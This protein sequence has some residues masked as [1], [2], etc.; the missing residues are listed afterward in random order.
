MGSHRRSHFGSSRRFIRF[1][2]SSHYLFCVL[3]C[4]CRCMQPLAP[5]PSQIHEPVVL[6]DELSK[7]RLYC[8]H[9]QHTLQSLIEGCPLGSNAGLQLIEDYVMQVKQQ[10]QPIF[11]D[12]EVPFQAFAFV[13]GRHR[14]FPSCPSSDAFVIAAVS[15][16]F[17]F[18]IQAHF[19]ELCTQRTVALSKFPKLAC[20][21]ASFGKPEE[22]LPVPTWHQWKLDAWAKLNP[23]WRDG[24]CPWH[25]SGPLYH[26]DGSK[27]VSLWHSENSTAGFYQY[28]RF[29]FS[30]WQ[31]DAETETWEEEDHL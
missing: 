30:S 22:F 14:I 19:S 13:G 29:Q 8:Q 7:K 6:D 4:I 2:T 25:Y 20:W 10:P 26:R 17:Q 1:P 18:H 31:F 23:R 9:L 16:R 28:V 21:E 12:D 5:I 11:F 15:K 3:F 24:S 27:L